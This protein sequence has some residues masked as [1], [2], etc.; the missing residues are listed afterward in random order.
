MDIQPS[1]SEELGKIRFFVI[2]IERAFCKGTLWI[3]G[4]RSAWKP[5]QG[6]RLYS[7]SMLPFG[8]KEVETGRGFFP[9]T[10]CE[11]CAPVQLL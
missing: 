1:C 6:K 10:V 4:K 8:G 11:I 7:V 9:S 3:L 5:S 2:L